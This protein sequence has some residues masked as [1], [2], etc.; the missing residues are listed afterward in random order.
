MVCWL[1]SNGSSTRATVIPEKN[2]KLLFSI[3]L[4]HQMT[5]LK[6]TFPLFL[7]YLNTLFAEVG[8]RTGFLDGG[9]VQFKRYAPDV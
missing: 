4:R 8:L 6:I 2:S 3:S 5:Y 7:K 1:C 9:I